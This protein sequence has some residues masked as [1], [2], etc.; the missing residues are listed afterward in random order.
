V[1]EMHPIHPPTRCFH[2]PEYGTIEWLKYVCHS[3]RNEFQDDP[4]VFSASLR[5]SVP[6]HGV[7]VQSEED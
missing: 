3:R 1:R 5:L 4:K 6:V 7:T 2:R